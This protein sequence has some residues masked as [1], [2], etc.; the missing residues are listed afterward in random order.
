MTDFNLWT[1]YID[2]SDRTIYR[3]NENS[4]KEINESLQ[5]LYAGIQ[6]AKIEA[7]NGQ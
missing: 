7:M 2:S 3:F 1:G 5:N 4:S 6:Q